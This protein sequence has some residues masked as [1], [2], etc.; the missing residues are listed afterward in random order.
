MPGTHA[1]LE[2]PFESDARNPEHTANTGAT[3]MPHRDPRPV[4]ALA[5]AIAAVL[6]AVVATVRKVRRQKP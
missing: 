1:P 5:L 6:S 2:T 4:A 3:L